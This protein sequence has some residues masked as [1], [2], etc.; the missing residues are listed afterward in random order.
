M[1]D[2]TDLRKC[3]EYNDAHFGIPHDPAAFTK[4][5]KFGKK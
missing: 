1:A 5:N 4:L 2:D 3:S